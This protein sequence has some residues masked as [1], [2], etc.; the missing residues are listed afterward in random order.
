MSREESAGPLGPSTRLSLDLGI[1]LLKLAD[2]KPGIIND[3]NGDLTLRLRRLQRFLPLNLPGG[4]DSPA[5]PAPLATKWRSKM[6]LTPKRNTRFTDVSF[7]A[8][9]KLMRRSNSL[10]NKSRGN[11][12]ELWRIPNGTGLKFPRGQSA[13]GAT[14]PCVTASNSR[15]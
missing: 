12:K 3:V 5:R 1:S 11:S 9:L 13:P 2:G 4:L 7:T 6:I 10:Y 8:V 14:L 15:N